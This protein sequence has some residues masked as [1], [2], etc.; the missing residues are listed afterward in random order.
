MI[1][2]YIILRKD[3]PTITGNPVSPQKLAVMTAH[4]SMV[5]LSR[6]VT[7]NSDEARVL[8]CIVL[9]YIFLQRLYSY[10]RECSYNR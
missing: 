5:F 10:F 2:Q 6:M 9:G 7:A 8:S 3:A 4:A 1:K